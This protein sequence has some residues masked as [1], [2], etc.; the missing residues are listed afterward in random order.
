MTKRNKTSKTAVR[1]PES[2]EEFKHRIT[3]MKREQETGKRYSV[4][5]GPRA[6]ECTLR[7]RFEAVGQKVAGLGHEAINKY[8][9]SQD[10]RKLLA[11][12]LDLLNHKGSPGVD[13]VLEAITAELVSRGYNHVLDVGT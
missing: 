10:D 5:G 2:V 8:V 13:V 11:A 9:T 3:R 4:I 12:H 7:Q 1:Q 6:S